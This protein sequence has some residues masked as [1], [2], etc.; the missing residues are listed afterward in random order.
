MANPSHAHILSNF[1]EFIATPIKLRLNTPLQDLA[2]RFNVS[3]S[4]LSRIYNIHV[5]YCY[6]HSSMTTY[7]VAWS[8]R[9]ETQYAWVLSH[10]SFGDNLTVIIDCLRF[11]YPPSNLPT[12]ACM[13]SSYKHHNTVWLLIG[14]APRGVVSLI[15]QAW[16][17]R[18]THPVLAKTYLVKVQLS[19]M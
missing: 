1:Q 19:L 18:V 8:S 9:T 4:T 7:Y 14:I 13:W 2:Y 5:G 11:F 10:T 16:G 3:L 6:G 15:S 17:G 12:R